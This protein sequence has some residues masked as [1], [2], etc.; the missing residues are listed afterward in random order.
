MVLQYKLDYSKLSDKQIVEKILAEPHDEEAAAYLLHERYSPLLHNLYNYFT[1]KDTWFDDC[2]D[3]LFVHLRGKDCAWH[4]LSTFEWR[5]TLG[6]WLKGVAFNKFR[7]ILSKLIE[8]RGHNLSIDNGDF[9]KPNNQIPDGDESNHERFMQKIML[10]EAIEKLE[11]DDLRFVILKRLEGYRSKE[12][13]EMLQ[14]RWKKYGIVKYNNKNEVVIP[15]QGYINVHVQ[16][17]KAM[18][19]TIMSN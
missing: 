9:T 2:I 17:A 11:D 15:D 12:I 16:R 19:R 7:D 5:S 13:A 6:Y 10:L 14:V 18:L 1:Q 4:T 8:N 3:E